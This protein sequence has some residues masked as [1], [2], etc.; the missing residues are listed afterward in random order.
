MELW[1]ETLGT[2]LVRADTVEQ[3]WWDVKHPAFVPLTLR[4]DQEVRQDAQAGFP[5][6]DL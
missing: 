4:S 1:S 2:R 3:V 5:T 6:G